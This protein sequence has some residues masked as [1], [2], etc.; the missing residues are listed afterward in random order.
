MATL[1]KKARKEETN[2]DMLANPERELSSKVPSSSILAANIEVR[3]A[4]DASQQRQTRRDQYD[5]FTPEEKAIIARGAIENGVTR[6]VVKYN[7]VL[8]NR[9]LKKS[10]V[11][12]WV[13]E[14]K[15]QLELRRC[16][17]VGLPTTVLKLENKKRGQPLLLGE[18][19]DQY[20]RQHVAELRRHGGVI[21]AEIV[22]AAAI[23]IV[24]NF[25]ANMLE[26][27]GG[28]YRVAMNGLKDY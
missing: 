25:E 9:T 24:K 21:N 2:N 15:W 26:I 3:V 23:R 5:K 8:Q 18:E 19:L 12:T 10:T 16:T 14:Y 20:T 7:E 27:N 22:S 17:G 6:T 4:L 11:R 13:S 1:F 28:H